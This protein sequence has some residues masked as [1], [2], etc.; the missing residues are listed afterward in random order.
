MNLFIIGGTGRTGKLLVSEALARGHAVHALARNPNGFT[1]PDAAGLKIFQGNPI[2][3]DVLR[4]AMA[5]CDAVLSA[6]NL[7][8]TS[9]W[10][11]APLRAPENLLSDCMSKVIPAMQE[12]GRRR[13]IVISTFG[14]DDSIREVPGWFRWLVEHSNIRFPYRDHW[15]QEELLSRSGLDWTILRPAGLTN[16]R[17]AKPVRVSFD[18]NPRPGLT[19]SR[20]AVAHFMLDELE[21][22]EYVGRRPTISWT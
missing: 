7:S 16:S 14:V 21:R 6:L 20:L 22:N 2:D 11:W 4:E 9:D 15:R 12:N 1:N 10:P 17:T 13:I 18:G 8:R 19:I 5:G 3:A